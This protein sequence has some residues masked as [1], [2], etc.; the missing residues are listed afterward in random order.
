[1]TTDDEPAV[2]EAK[3]AAKSAKRAAKEA[4]RTADLVRENERTRRIEEAAK[5][6]GGLSFGHIVLAILGALFVWYV[7]LPMGLMAGCAAILAAVASQ[8]SG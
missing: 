4:A 8:V 7:V 1:M 2:R 5:S 3:R 6:D